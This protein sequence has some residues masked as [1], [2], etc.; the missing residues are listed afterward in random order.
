MATRGF[1]IY[2]RPLLDGHCIK[3]VQGDPDSIVNGRSLDNVVGKVDILD[4][5]E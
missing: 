5:C 4:A 3:K 2:I 1:L